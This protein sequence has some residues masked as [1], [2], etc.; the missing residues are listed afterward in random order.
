MAKNN[1][2]SHYDVVIIG[3]G[4]G[5][6]NCAKFLEKSDLKVLLLEKNPV[7]GPKI[8]AGG[9]TTKDL[10]YL[11]IPQDIID[12]SYNQIVFETPK[13]ATC[14]KAKNAFVCTIDRH[15]F[16]QWQLGQ[17]KKTT[18][19]TEKKVVKIMKNS[20]LLE[21]GEEIFFKYLVGADG[22]NSIVRRHLGIK[23][24]NI[25]IGIQYII[26]IKKEYKKELVL[27]FSNKEFS[28][29]YGWIFP[30]KDYLSIG[31]GGIKGK[32]DFGKLKKNLENWIKKLGIEIKDGRFEGFVINSDMSECDFGNIFLVGDAAGLASPL[33]GEGIYSALVSGQ[34]IAE[35]IIGPDKK[36]DK[37]SQLKNLLSSHRKIAKT[38]ERAGIL[39]QTIFNKVAKKLKNEELV[40][41]L[42]KKFS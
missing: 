42:V 7:I 6:L 5:G 32:S 20:V 15:K 2:D 25:G 16:G 18:V 3:A 35:K 19:L 27:R 37:I 34:E 24:E 39:R 38:I 12:Y 30:H 8:C 22:S 10:A 14:A 1:L 9:I 4:P 31:T 11:K 40:Q 41:E 17:L 21:T 33:T 29:F 23:S 36:L 28:L 26:P 13:I